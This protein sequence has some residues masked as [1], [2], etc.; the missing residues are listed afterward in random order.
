MRKISLW[1]NRYQ[2]EF[3][4]GG[5][6]GS[7]TTFAVVA[8]ATGAKFGTE[9]II[10][11]GLANLLADGLS[12]SIGSYLSAK[13]EVNYFQKH[14]ENEYWSV[15]NK[16]EEE[17]EEI[18]KI[19]ERKGFKGETL[20]EIVKVI[21]SNQHIWV[22]E[23]MK[24]ELKMMEAAKQ[25]LQKGIA[26]YLSFIAVGMIPLTVYLI[27]LLLPQNRLPLFFI[28]CFLTF[29]AF[30]FIG[31]LKSHLNHVNRIKGV[32]ETLLLGGVAALV[33]YFAGSALEHLIL[34]N[35]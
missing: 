32:A 21:T 10:I 35:I 33:A 17:T 25:P 11:L 9:V 7:V 18:R 1:F 12:M 23:M 26:T 15:R 13:A 28:S 22:E 5:I 24:D 2:T 30:L 6:D 20:E 14:K 4:Y 34:K 16:P 19:Y 8:G 31:Y 3:I 27:D 29:S